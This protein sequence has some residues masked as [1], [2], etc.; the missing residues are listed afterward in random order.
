LTSKVIANGIRQHYH[1]SGEGQQLV[2]FI[3]GLV[4]D[5][6]SSWYFTLAPGIARHSTV[7]LYD[8]RGHGRSECPASGYRVTD[9]V[10]DLRSLINELGLQ[11]RPLH[12]VANSFGGIV[13]TSFAHMYP[14]SVSSLILLDA[15]LP[16]RDCI[17]MMSASMAMT[18]EEKKKA[19]E[20]DFQ[21][22]PGKKNPLK[23]KKLAEKTRLLLEQ[24]SL[25]EDLKTSDLLSDADFSAIRVPVLAVY[26]EHSDIH[27]QGEKL[28]RLLPGCR[29]VT[30]D[31]GS[32]SIVWEQTEYLGELL[33]AWLT[34][35]NSVIHPDRVGAG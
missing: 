20:D 31:E 18:E 5:D 2:V 23:I 21:N 33:G 25:V 4:M 28:S 35:I 6:L 22:W 29:F 13:A 8:M 34:D 16:N 12:L 10:C 19:V 24:T 27:A 17:D 9:F 11:D 3:H 7:L 1:L 26:G 32:H 15:H 30:L 14:G